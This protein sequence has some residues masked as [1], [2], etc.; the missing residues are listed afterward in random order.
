M[1]SIGRSSEAERRHVRT[2]C[3]ASSRLG[4]VGQAGGER[5]ASGFLGQGLRDPL[6]L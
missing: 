5:L 3:S 2:A 6:G 1:V 4:L